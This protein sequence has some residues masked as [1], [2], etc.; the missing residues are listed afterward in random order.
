MERP[1]SGSDCNCDYDEGQDRAVEGCV[2]R[3]HKDPVGSDYGNKTLRELL[4]G[5]YASPE[6]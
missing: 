3:G 2:A 6:T 1:R 5:S 4:A